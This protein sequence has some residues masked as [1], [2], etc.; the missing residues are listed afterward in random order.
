MSE[1]N[2]HIEQFFKKHLDVEQS[3]FLEE[4]WAQME[5]K[6]DDAGIGVPPPTNQGGIGMVKG[7]VILFFACGIAFLLGWYL[8]TPNSEATSVG[9]TQTTSTP[10][11][12]PGK[13]QKRST[14]K[15]IPEEPVDDTDQE[16]VSSK[17]ITPS[18]E[19]ESKVMVSAKTYSD[20][21]QNNTSSQNYTSSRNTELPTLSATPPP[22]ADN[23]NESEVGIPYEPGLVINSITT[24]PEYPIAINF[25]DMN[26]NL[27]SLLTGRVICPSAPRIVRWTDWSVG[28]SLAP[29]INSLGLSGRP[30]VTGKIGLR[31]YWDVLDRLSIQSGVF[32]NKK[33]YT[34]TGEEYH[35]PAGYWENNTDG[36]IPSTIEGSC[37]VI[38]I[39]IMIGYEWLRNERWSYA[40]NLGLSNYILLDEEYNYDFGY[41]GAGTGAY[42]WTTDENTALPWSIANLS[43]SG[44]YHWK[45]KTSIIIEPFIQVPLK[46]IGWGN[47]DLYGYG[48]LFTIKQNLK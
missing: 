43:I 45:P 15:E 5:A 44:S 17:S 7:V 19:P 40:T 34:A 26:Q 2:N 9:A 47:V 20:E 30:N 39:P 14:T 42:S 25:S 1:E 37:R 22:P 6:L 21:I 4:D 23:R 18:V 31:I 28:L 16:A 46:E 36:R 48:I 24:L 29:D 8:H 10:I 35:P 38:D 3:S 11:E 41:S 32:Y 27:G 12:I 33:Q 13:Q